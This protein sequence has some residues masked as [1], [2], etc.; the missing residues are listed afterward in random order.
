MADAAHLVRRQAEILPGVFLGD[1]GDTKSLVK[2][3]QLGFACWELSSFLV[4]HDV[5]CWSKE[6]GGD[7]SF[8]KTRK[9]L[10]RKQLIIPHS[11]PLA[12]REKD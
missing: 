1:V 6:R 2:V 10:L 8:C 9:L 12:P 4:P 3:F 11:E 5:W 7:K